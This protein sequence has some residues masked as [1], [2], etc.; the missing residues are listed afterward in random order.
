LSYFTHE[1]TSNDRIQY[2]LDFEGAA[3]K[4]VR[5]LEH[6]S[7]DVVKPALKTVGNIISGYDTQTQTMLDVDVLPRLLVLLLSP[8]PAIKKEA[9]WAISNI[10]AG[11]PKQIQKIIDNDIFP[12]IITL[13]K[14]SSAEVRN[15]A[16]WTIYNAL[17]G[18]EMNQ[19]IEIADYKAIVFLCTLLD[20]SNDPTVII[21]ALHC[22][23][24]IL[25][26]G[27]VNKTEGSRN[28]YAVLVEANKCLD[29][30][31]SL[32]THDNLEIFNK[33]NSIYDTFFGGGVDKMED[34]IQTDVIE[35]FEF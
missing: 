25:L 16:V 17:T 1:L 10:A 18:G 3:E 27:N 15:E 7:S 4:L 5:L 9:C 29:L 28:P 26:V 34:E 33:A 22:I 2:V 35:N 20:E 11:S 32:Q 13:L 6:S 31:E 23:E 21:T 24:K 19:I 12:L 30:I 14:D 8:R